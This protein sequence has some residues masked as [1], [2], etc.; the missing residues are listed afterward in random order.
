MVI[1]A[2]AAAGASFSSHKVYTPLEWGTNDEIVRQFLVDGESDGGRHATLS[3][4]HGVDGQLKR[5]FDGAGGCM[6][7][8]AL[9][10]T[11]RDVEGQGDG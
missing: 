2:N 8:Q 3:V 10:Y 5:G 4:H 6:S 9:W 11:R 1:A 7:Q